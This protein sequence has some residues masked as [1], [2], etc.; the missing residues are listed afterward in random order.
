MAQFLRCT[1]LIPDLRILWMGITP[2]SAISLYGP[3]PGTRE[4]L[5]RVCVTAE[6]RTDFHFV[7]VILIN[8]PF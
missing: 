7:R 5:Y 3:E 1:W 8:G 4:L 2:G 6:G